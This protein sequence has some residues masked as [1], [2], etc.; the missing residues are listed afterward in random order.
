MSNINTLA[1]TATRSATVLPTLGCAY[2]ASVQGTRVGAAAQAIFGFAGMPTR[3]H[4]D[5]DNSVWG[6]LAWRPPIT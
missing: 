5:A 2:R 4:V 6:A 3:G 1:T